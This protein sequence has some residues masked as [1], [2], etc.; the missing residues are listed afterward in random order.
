MS[1]KLT[2]SV[3]DIEQSARGL[4]PPDLFERWFGLRGDPLW[5]TNFN[6]IDGFDSVYL[7]P[8]V[9]AAEPN[10]VMATTV[11][12][13]HIRFPVYLAPAGGQIRFN[14]EGEL[15][16]A[17]AAAAAGTI[18]T[19]SFG[20][21][22]SLEEVRDVSDGQL[23]FQL[24]LLRDRG[25]C[26]EILQRA[27]HLDYRAVVLTVDQ[28]GTRTR[29]R[30]GTNYSL[31]M[32]RQPQGLSTNTSAFGNLRGTGIDTEEDM[33]EAME[34]RLHWDCVDWVRETTSMPVV[35]KGIQTPQ[36]ALLAVEHGASA[37]VVSNHGGH[38]LV[39]APA[40]IHS[41]PS[42]VDAV[43]DRIEVYLDGGIRRG[44]DVLKALA[45]GARAV[46]IGRGMYWG[47]AAGGEDGVKTVLDVLYEELYIA[48]LYCSVAD[49]TK[50]DRSLVRL[51]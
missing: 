27:E 7:L 45:V 26:A 14:P 18:F 51:P 3:A 16:S 35:V 36:D 21:S 17:R 25:L 10:M 13:T 2:T 42:I 19:I 24:Y 48:G 31:R 11:L 4:L 46:G 33:I 41:L 22:Y 30:D 6:N 40:T 49:V 29:E 44:T 28:P 43:G 9:L 38:S 37:I 12:G 34:P 20:S 5:S 50:V 23:M 32:A 1:E 47:L 39:G 8:R 15:A